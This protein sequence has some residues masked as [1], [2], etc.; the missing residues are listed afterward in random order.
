MPAIL[1]REAG[2]LIFFKEFRP[3]TDDQIGAAVRS[4][5]GC[6][7]ALLEHVDLKPILEDAEGAEVTVPP[8]FDPKPSG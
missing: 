2:W 6:Q 3:Y 8:D 7:A 1:Q 5:R 4:I